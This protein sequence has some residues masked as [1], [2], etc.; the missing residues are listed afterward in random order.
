[1]IKREITRIP[2]KLE[3]I[4]SEYDEF[5]SQMVQMKRLKEMLT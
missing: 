5:T 1:M 3:D 2:M 4:K